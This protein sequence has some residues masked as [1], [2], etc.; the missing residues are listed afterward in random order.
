MLFDNRNSRQRQFE[1]YEQNYKFVFNICYRI[2]GNKM[3]AENV[4]Q[5][6]FFKIFD[7]MGNIKQENKFHAWIKSIAVNKSIDF[8]R[9]KKIIFEPLNDVDVDDDDNDDNGE[10]A[11]VDEVENLT[12]ETIL[13]AIS[14]LP[15][16]YRT[17][18]SLRLFE[19]Y[20]FEDVAKLLK[21]KPV[22][23]RSQYSRGRQKLIEI[24][25]QINK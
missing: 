23:V 22:S 5:E 24:Y 1:I 18:L 13:Q 25:K 3:D 17:I 2:I 8:M 15:D 16:G 21:I 12:V 19:D 11:D 10:V 20:S 14:L 4:M 9:K 7:N 6:C